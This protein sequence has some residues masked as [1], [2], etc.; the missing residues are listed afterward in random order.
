MRVT[1]RTKAVG[2]NDLMMVVV[3]IL[4]AGVVLLVL[5]LAELNPQQQPK[6]MSSGTGKSVTHEQSSG[7][8]E[9]DPLGAL[10]WPWWYVL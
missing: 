9:E 5:C 2:K 10:G 6:D 3:C 7:E 1:E 8:G 4:S